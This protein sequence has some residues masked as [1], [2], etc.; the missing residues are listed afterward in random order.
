MRNW[1]KQLGA[2]VSLV[3]TLGVS[4]TALAYPPQC[5]CST[6]CYYG[7][8]RFSCA[9]EI[10]AD[11]CRVGSTQASLTQEQQKPQEQQDASRNMCTEQDQQSA[12]SES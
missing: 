10:C 11:Q 5:S 6:P 1:M 9:D 3:F 8:K 4:S 2:S 12:S 7:T